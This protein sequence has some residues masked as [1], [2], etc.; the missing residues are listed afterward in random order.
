MFLV[1]RGQGHD[2]GIAHPDLQIVHTLHEYTD[3]TLRTLRT[4]DCL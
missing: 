3:T 1:H 4:I 2:L